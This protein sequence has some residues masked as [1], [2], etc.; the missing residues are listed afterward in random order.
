M[1]NDEFITPAQMIE[2]QLKERGWTQRTLSMVLGLSEKT[3][4]SIMNALTKISNE[5]ALQLQQAL[6]LDAYS[7]LKLQAS[8]ELKKAQLV[9]RPD[10][11]L[12]TRATVF[13]DLPVSEM[14]SRGWLE[15]VSDLW[16]SRLDEALCKFFGTASIDEIEVLPHAAKKTDVMGEATAAQIT[17]LYRAKQIAKTTLVGRYSASA[18]NAAIKELKTLLSSTQGAR[19]VPKILSDCGIRL[20]IVQSLESAKIDGV[21]FWL[22]EKSPVIGLSLRFDRI[23]NFWFVLR[24]EL[25]HVIQKHG[26]SSVMMDANLEG[27]R[28]GTGSSVTEEERIANAAA[29]E[30]CVPQAQLQHF[31]RV[32]SPFYAERDIRGFAATYKIHPGIVAGQLQRSLNRYDLF[33]NHLVKVKS[34][35]APNAMVDGWGDVAPIH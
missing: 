35:V 4:S 34:V 15:G 3:V 33:R 19:K 20:V 25:E 31:I 24:H 30:F 1:N 22:D 14:I 21:C 7:L 17:W 6:Q 2:A 26:Q 10:P 12:A 5:L 8:F 9:F 11:A 13:G 32:K 27:D 18:V 29:A 16:D 28:A 23:D